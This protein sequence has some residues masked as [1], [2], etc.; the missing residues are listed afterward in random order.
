MHV[1]N[2]DQIVAADS[3]GELTIWDVKTGSC[4]KKI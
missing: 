3:D 1:L 4:I 2:Y